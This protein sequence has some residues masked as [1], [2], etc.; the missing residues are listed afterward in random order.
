MLIS[1]V[2]LLGGFVLLIIG[3]DTLIKGAVGLAERFAVPPLIIGLTIVAFG[4]S[5]PELFVSLDAVFANQPGLAVGNVVGSNIANVLLV[6]GI[7]ALISTMSPTE[8]GVRRNVFAMLVATALFMAMMGFQ[9]ELTRVSGGILF[10]L[11]IAYLVWQFVNAR[12]N[13]VAPTFLDEE[14]VDAKGQSGLGIGLRIVAGLICLP[15]GAEL[16]VT[17]ASSIASSWGVPETII[18]LAIVGIGTSLPELATSITAAWRGHGAVAFGNVVGSNLFNI[19]SIMGLTALIVPFDVDQRIIDVDMWVMAAAAIVLAIVVFGRI[20]MG[21][22][23]G[24][25]LT[26]AFII[27]LYTLFAWS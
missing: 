18:G 20:R 6:I 8:R 11:L 22:A 24:A 27:Y 23:L 9:G 25:L 19:L 7:P 14:E 13:N 2:S 16:T 12:S 17:G 15:L 5:A 26:A 4:T 10:A 21:K 3:G 1:Y